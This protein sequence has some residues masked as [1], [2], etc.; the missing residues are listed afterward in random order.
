[1]LSLLLGLDLIGWFGGLGLTRIV[2]P[3]GLGLLPQGDLSQ[4][5][6]RCPLPSPCGTA[7]VAPGPGSPSS[8]PLPNPVVRRQPWEPLGTLANVVLGV[9]PPR[10]L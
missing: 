5:L 7:G 6:V 3:R 9:Q 2:S 4:R 10:G 8:C 1:M